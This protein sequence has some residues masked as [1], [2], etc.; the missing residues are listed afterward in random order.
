MQN[1]FHHEDVPP[2]NWLDELHSFNIPA[3]WDIQISD[4]QR[5]NLANR[6]QEQLN[7]WRVALREQVKKI[8]ARYD[9]SNRDVM[10]KML[11]PY[12]ML[13]ELGTDLHT[14]LRDLMDRVKNGRA[15]P[16]QFEFGSRIFGDLETERWKLGERPDEQ[17]WR[18]FMTVER[19]YMS[20]TKEFKTQSRGYDNA[21][22]GV[23]EAQADLEKLTA[24]YQKKKGFLQIGLR[25]FIVI[26]T[27]VFCLVL[28]AAFLLI[29][30]PPVAIANEI[31]AGIMLIFAVI[32][33]IAAIMIARRQRQYLLPTR[34]TIKEVQAEYQAM[35]KTFS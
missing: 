11:T 9:A 13:D 35:R 31:F 14:Q 25:L 34:E 10:K 19:R 23:T 21:K 3:A 1:A 20:L 6:A 32:A 33:A 26:L 18:D 27:T 4:A 2:Q 28:G 30:L 17:R 24:S 12:R 15:I 16:Q 5:R 8:E 22:K 29:E 7:D